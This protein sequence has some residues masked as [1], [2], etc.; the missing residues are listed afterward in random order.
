M[1]A[2]GVAEV[3]GGSFDHLFFDHLLISKD[4]D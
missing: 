3:K 1:S 2:E 4:P